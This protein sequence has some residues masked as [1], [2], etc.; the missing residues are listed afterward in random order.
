MVGDPEQAAVPLDGWFL[1]DGAVVAR[2]GRVA[3]NGR[4]GAVRAE[5]MSP[6]ADGLTSSEEV[7]F[8]ARGERFVGRAASFEPAPDVRGLFVV[9]ASL[10]AALAPLRRLQRT[11]AAVTAAVMLI[12]TFACR[13][14]ARLIADPVEQLVAGTERIARGEFGVKVDSTRRDELGQLARS[15]NQMA[16]GLEQRDLIKETFGKFVHPKI[17]EGFLADPAKLCLGGEKR[18][19]T[20]FFSD[21]ANFTAL[22]EKLGPTE[23]VPLLNRHLGDV[24]E[25]VAETR[26][27]VDKFIGDAVMAF[28]G[29]PLDVGHAEDACLAALG[30]VERTRELAG[31]C[32]ELGCP[33]LYVRIGIATGEV[34]VGN[35]GSPNKYN[36]TVMGDIV[37]LGSRL[38]GLN[39]VYGT[40]ILVAGRTASEAGDSIVAR[41]IDVARVVGRREPVSLYEVLAPAGDGAEA[42]ER[43]S[44]AYAAALLRYESRDWAQGQEAFARV[45]SRW[46]DDGPARVMMERCAAFL[47]RDPSGDWDGVW[48]IDSK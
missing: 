25:I 15:F 38:E 1:I 19:Q 29:P 18:V 36:Y 2:S 24:A 45:T 41:K 17:V 10:D 7:T 5:G 8:R 9:A 47:E 6:A 48:E 27:I 4:P 37:N 22:S 40:Q 16:A 20:I 31:V 30:C 43:R 35:I 34:L 21:L 12:A 42:L 11:L 28:W 14:V 33:A 44:Q 3:L 13:K 39:K 23:L 46:P 32:S 26:G